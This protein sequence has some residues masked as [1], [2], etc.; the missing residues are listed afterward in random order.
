MAVWVFFLC[1]PPCPKQPKTSFPFYKFFYQTISARISANM[2]YISW[3][4]ENDEFFFDNYLENSPNK[5]LQ[6]Y[7]NLTIGGLNKNSI[8]TT[9]SISEIGVSLTVSANQISFKMWQL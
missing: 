9:N 6:T 7:P 3:N 8:L 1:S 5:Y 4:S 2:H